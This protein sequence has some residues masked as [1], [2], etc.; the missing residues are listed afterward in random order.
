[1]IVKYQ[2]PQIKGGAD[3]SSRTNQNMQDGTTSI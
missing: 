2:P 1:V 3:G